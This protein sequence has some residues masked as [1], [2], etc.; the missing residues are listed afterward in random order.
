MNRRDFLSG[1]ATAALS[2][3]L[4]PGCAAGAPMPGARRRLL[5]YTRSVGWMHDVVK[6]AA[7]GGPSVVERAVSA[8]GARHGWEVT[9]SRDG[10]VFQPERL[11]EFDAFFF[12]TRGELTTP[13]TDGQP[14]MAPGGKQALLAAVRGGR[15]FVGVHS[16]SDTFHSQPDPSTAEGR[17]RR[18]GVRVDPFIEMLGGEFMSHAEPQAATLRVTDPAFP[19]MAA[20]PPG[21][22]FGEWY[23]LVNLN[24]GMRVLAVLETAGMEGPEY[25]RRPYPVVWARPYGRGRVFYSALGHFAEEW[26]DP[27]HLGMLAGALRWALGDAPAGVVTNVA[28]AAPGLADFPAMP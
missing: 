26:S 12:F 14:P 11:A 8:L 25:R 18:T 15:G 9:C 20:L 17:A 4:L 22:R 13:G 6:P 1:V 23:S 5:C 28:E 2:A 19:G 21:P 7:D 3:S 24:P 10:A 16:A 27:A